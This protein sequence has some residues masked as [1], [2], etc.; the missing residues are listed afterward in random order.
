MI[1][2]GLSGGEAFGEALVA[3]GILLIII[4][5]MTSEVGAGLLLIML[6]IWYIGLGLCYI[7]EDPNYF[8]F[9]V[10]FSTL[11]I[12]I[13][14]GLGGAALSLPAILSFALSVLSAILGL[15]LGKNAEG[16][17]QS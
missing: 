12:T 7:Y 1:S 13:V 2:G 16:L 17:C 4:G 8:L 9:A 11:P 14:L 6:G 10:A 5:T 3:I 15:E